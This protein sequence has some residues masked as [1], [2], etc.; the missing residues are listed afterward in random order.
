M[1]YSLQSDGKYV[2]IVAIMS[3]AITAFATAR[4][5]D[6]LYGKL[7]LFSVVLL[8]CS[9]A[10]FF[11]YLLICLKVIPISLGELKFHGRQDYLPR[12]NSPTDNAPKK[13]KNKLKNLTYT[14]LT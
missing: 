10:C 12:D 9:S 8:C 11:W 4:M 5:T 7:K 2:A 3:S 13:T 1:V 6:F 14:K